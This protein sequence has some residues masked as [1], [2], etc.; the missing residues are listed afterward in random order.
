M[1]HTPRMA[2]GWVNHGLIFNFGWTIPLIVK[3]CLVAGFRV[4]VIFQRCVT[5]YMS[6]FCFSASLFFTPSLSQVMCD[7]ESSGW[8]FTLIWNT[9]REWMCPICTVSGLM[10][11]WCL[12]P[13]HMIEHLPSVSIMHAQHMHS[14]S[15]T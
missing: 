3:L 10:R 1:S 5:D 11:S 4:S 7:G 14:L 8:V 6:A 13:R 2:S 15:V 12:H 9:N